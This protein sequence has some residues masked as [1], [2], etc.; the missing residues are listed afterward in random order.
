MVRYGLIALRLTFWIALASLPIVTDLVVTEFMVTDCSPGSDCLV[1]AMPLIVNIG[2]ITIF[3][4]IFLWPICIWFLGGE[5]VFKKLR[6]NYG[7][8]V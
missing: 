6:G 1:Q 4:R 2:I 8:T 5:W 7:D 3:E